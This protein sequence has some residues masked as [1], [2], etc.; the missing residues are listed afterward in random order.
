M[1]R[2]STVALVIVVIPFITDP[3]DSGPLPKRTT[4]A[5]R[6]GGTSEYDRPVI[7]DVFALL[8]VHFVNRRQHAS[9]MMRF[10]K[11]HEEPGCE[12][13]C[14]PVGERALATSYSTILRHI[15]GL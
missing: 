14:H 9:A 3:Q 2:G 10:V 6:R 15:S 4:K 8:E 12:H 7:N 5:R 13:G 11:I 1:G